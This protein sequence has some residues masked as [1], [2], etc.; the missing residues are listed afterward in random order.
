VLDPDAVTRTKTL[1]AE[2]MA[3]KL[4]DALPGADQKLRASVWAFLR[5]M[6]SPRLTALNR[7]A[8]LPD[9]DIESTVDLG[10]HRADTEL[11]ALDLDDDNAPY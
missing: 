1:G 4:A 8:F 2:R 9:A 3:R 11:G 10:A 7:D 6:L 5:P